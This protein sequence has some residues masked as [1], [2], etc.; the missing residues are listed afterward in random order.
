VLEAEGYNG[1]NELVISVKYF[2]TPGKIFLFTFVLE[3]NCNCE[4]YKIFIGHY[5]FNLFVRKKIK[6]LRILNYHGLDVVSCRR[7]NQCFVP[8]GKRTW[9]PSEMSE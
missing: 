9:Q 6:L 7:S 8:D 1:G 4:S 3:N 2:Y 5:K